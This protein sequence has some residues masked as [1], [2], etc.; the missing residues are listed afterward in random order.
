MEW[1][2]PKPTHNRTPDC[3]VFR[4]TDAAECTFPIE[5]LTVAVYIDPASN[6]DMAT[7]EDLKQLPDDI[8][9]E[10]APLV[11]RGGQGEVGLI[12]SLG[13]RA[14]SLLAYTAASA[15]A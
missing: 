1:I 6:L 11:K 7:L 14:I 5:P 3:R 2:T 15:A 8:E 12:H 10:L 9:A 4:R 13:K